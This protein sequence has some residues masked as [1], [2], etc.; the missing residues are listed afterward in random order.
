MPARSNGGESQRR[1]DGAIEWR[2]RDTFRVRVTNGVDPVTGRRRYL[3]ASGK[4]NAKAAERAL[5]DLLGRRDN[6]LQVQPRRLTVRE[7]ALP[8]LEG[9][10][11]DG[12]VGP[13]AAENYR[14]ILKRRILP[15]MGEIRLPDLRP[16]QVLAFKTG[17]LEEGLAPATVTKILG[18]LRRCLQ[19]ALAADL[20]TRNPAAVVPNPSLTG[21]SAER[22]ALSEGEV[23]LLLQ[24]AEGTPF[25]VAIRLALATGM[26][27]S[28]MLGLRWQDVDLTR[29][30][31]LVRQ[32]L[33]HI[34]GEFQVLPPKTQ[35]S[36]RTIELSAATVAMLREHHAAQA[37]ERERLAAIWHDLD[38][39]FP[40]PDG[41]PLHRRIFYRDFMLVVEAS[42]IADFSTITWHGLRHTAAS[43]WIKAGVDIFTVSRRLG[44]S[45]ASFTMDVYGHMLAGQQQAAAEALDQLLAT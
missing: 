3:F 13:R 29:K 17:L 16:E 36:H 44:H 4:G 31:L 5:R 42:T 14:T 24:A 41:Q 25:A 34:A 21:T 22:R 26:R 23:G 19:G 45:Q 39:V 33:Q 12:V 11:A 15:A 8:W 27:Q 32:T 18:L 37:K 35:R 40:A 43:L 2:G 10:I 7:W 20:I 30:T 38:L 9:R 6:G 1:A 28:E